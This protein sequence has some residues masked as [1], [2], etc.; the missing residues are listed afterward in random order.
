LDKARSHSNL[1]YS[2]HMLHGTRD[3]SAAQRH[4]CEGR[5]CNFK[6]WY[7]HLIAFLNHFWLIISQLQFNF[8]NIHLPNNPLLKPHSIPGRD[9]LHSLQSE[10][11]SATNVAATAIPSAISKG[12]SAASAATAIPINTVKG[13][14]P[15]NCSLGTKQF[16]VGFEN[17]TE[18][19]NL[20]LNLSN[21]VPEAVVNF[22]G[23][24]V[25][26]LQPLPEILAKVTVTNIQDCLIL[27]LVLMLVMSIILYFALR[28]SIRIG[29]VIIFV[30]GLTCCVPFFIPTVVLFAVQS[31]IESLPSSIEVQK[32]GVSNYCLGVLCCGVVMTL[33][34]TFSPILA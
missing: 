2:F 4:I 16:C 26:A 12:Q 3:P 10:A 15:R 14:I 7:R 19:N 9:F 30:A 21:I 17:R 33:L 31:K 18:C 24:Q 25:Q 6:G 11:Q 34:A 29:M 20:P 27:G 23:D 1:R 8:T 32:G 5:H 28:L 13:M 22:V